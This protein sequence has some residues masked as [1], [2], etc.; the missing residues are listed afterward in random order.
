MY[1]DLPEVQTKVKP[2]IPECFGY[3]VPLIEL[4]VYHLASEPIYKYFVM[5]LYVK[6]PCLCC[7]KE[8]A[9]EMKKLTIICWPPDVSNC[10]A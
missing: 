5:V 6:I 10:C 9:L 1:N 8:I 2:V 7:E 4:S 3:F